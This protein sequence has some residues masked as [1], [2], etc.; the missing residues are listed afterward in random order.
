MST[1]EN[2][3]HPKASLNVAWTGAAASAGSRVWLRPFA[4]AS[5]GIAQIIDGLAAFGAA[6]YLGVEPLT[7]DIWRSAEAERDRCAD[8]PQFD[9]AS[10]G[11]GDR[12]RK[13]VI[14]SAKTEI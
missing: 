2:W 12:R 10:G 8:P 9:A 5:W 4:L 11:H 6:L 3:S 1:E 14:S 7:W 13:S